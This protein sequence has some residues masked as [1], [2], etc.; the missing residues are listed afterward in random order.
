MNVAYTERNDG[1]GNSLIYE[2]SYLL[3]DIAVSDNGFL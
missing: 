1:V 2:L 3:R